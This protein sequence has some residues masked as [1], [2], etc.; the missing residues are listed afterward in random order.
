MSGYS[1]EGGGRL[2]EVPNLIDTGLLESV[3]D[4]AK[5]VDYSKALG[6]LYADKQTQAKLAVA[7]NLHDQIDYE[8][9]QR[10][11]DLAGLKA[12]RAE[13]EMHVRKLSDPKY[14]EALA[15]E[16]AATIAENA[17]KADADAAGRFAAEK[18][19]AELGL[20]K[21]A[22]AVDGKID[23]LKLGTDVQK[24]KQRN[25]FIGQGYT[26]DEARQQTGPTSQEANDTPATEE[27]PAGDSSDLSAAPAPDAASLVLAPTDS[28]AAA[29]A[30]GAAPVAAPAAATAL[31]AGIAPN[32][33]QSLQAAKEAVRVQVA[34]AN[35][36][37][38]RYVTDKQMEDAIGI[39]TIKEVFVDPK[40]QDSYE[41]QVTRGRD[42]T[43]YKTSAPILHERSKT[44]QTIDTEAAKDYQ[45]YTQN[46]GAARDK[47]DIA[48][49][50][51]AISILK[52]GKTTVSGALTSLLPEGIRNVVLSDKGLKVPQMIK[53]VVQNHLKE[54]FGGRIS[55][56]EV[57]NAMELVF[58]PALSESTNAATSEHVRRDIVDAMENKRASMQFFGEHGT[59]EGFTPK[60][61]RDD[62]G[63]ST[64][65]SSSSSPAAGPQIGDKKYLN[66]REYTLSKNEVTGK[67]E[68]IAGQ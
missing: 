24:I 26:A 51:E 25:A 53:S 13:A 58:N 39:T 66:G 29:P 3:I 54:I 45:D 49:L 4:S 20:D 33:P 36:I 42:G 65:T 34:R 23:Y 14:Q 5:P 63:P 50:D 55:N 52:D 32:A 19:A 60:S 48:T 64:A 8:E 11:A 7:N 47:N 56:M 41:A 61:L 31:P 59:L 22:Y 6:Q 30:P 57:K 28:L 17:R 35:K 16:Y 15:S 18:D 40:T 2:G 43:I 27:A 67:R 62:S 68:W 38:P 37:P 46:R 21:N 44:Q 9:A 1:N 12:K 10:K